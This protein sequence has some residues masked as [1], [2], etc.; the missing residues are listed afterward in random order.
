MVSADLVQLSDAGSALENRLA[1]TLISEEFVGLDGGPCSWRAEEGFELRVQAS[2]RGCW[3]ASI[4]P[5]ATT[6]FASWSPEHVH[7]L[8]GD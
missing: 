5:G 2:Q 7:I 6:M 4:C 3:S 8:P 1:C